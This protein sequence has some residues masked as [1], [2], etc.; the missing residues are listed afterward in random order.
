MDRNDKWQLVRDIFEKG[1]V[2]KLTW[3]AKSNSYNFKL[4]CKVN[5]EISTGHPNNG[6]TLTL[7]P[8]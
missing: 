3:K 2:V 6:S 4:A 7:T 8:S 1:N 5:V